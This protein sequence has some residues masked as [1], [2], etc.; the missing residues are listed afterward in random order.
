[1]E[2]NDD[3]NIIKKTLLPI[4]QNS[5]FITSY[6]IKNLD[7]LK[8][9]YFIIKKYIN[10]EKNIKLN[11]RKN[12]ILSYPVNIKKENKFIPNAIKTHILNNVKNQKQITLNLN[13]REINICISK[14]T[15]FKTNEINHL[16]KKI[17]TMISFFDYISNDKLVPLNLFIYLT[18]FKKKL[19][20]NKTDIIST[21]NVNSGVTSYYNNFREIVIYR[22]EEL[23]K[24]LFHELIHYYDFDIKSTIDVTTNKLF[25]NNCFKLYGETYTEIWSR[26]LNIMFIAIEKTDN[27]EDYYKFLNISLYIESLFSF[28]QGLKILKYNNI[29]YNTIRT[30]NN[31]N[32]NNNNEKIYNE[33][34][35]SYC[36]YVLTGLL[37]MDIGNFIDLCN[38]N[39]K[40]N[41]NNKI[42][43]NKNQ[44]NHYKFIDLMLNI[45]NSDKFIKIEKLLSNYNILNNTLRMS[46]IE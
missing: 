32:N 1:M 36:Y 33:N 35:N 18:K 42:K 6:K 7:T 29:T 19:P 3:L 44:N 15:P 13:N 27:Y 37:M 43:F 4:L 17:I 14:E 11:I 24:V 45:L 10:Q 25:I 28:F 21:L 38:K 31:N 20:K 22:E 46:I 40:N 9:M 8:Q 5:D 41:K 39:N 23:I 34:T 2:I 26:M 30:N 12:K 16:F